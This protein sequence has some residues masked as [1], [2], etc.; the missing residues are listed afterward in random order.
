MKHILSDVTTG[1]VTEVLF[2]D[3]EIAQ[4]ATNDAA[5]AI[6]APLR[7]AVEVRSERDSRL[8][9]TDFHALSDTDMSEAM[10]T[11]RQALRDIPTQD[12]FPHE[13]TWPVSP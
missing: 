11:Y 1:E 4:K 10:T 12:G 5:E 9:K 8:V 6:A 2:T 3:A 7:K 13:V